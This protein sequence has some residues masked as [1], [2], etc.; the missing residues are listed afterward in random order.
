MTDE[1]QVAI[2][3][4]WIKDALAADVEIRKTEIN[5]T[6]DDDKHV[7]IEG[8]LGGEEDDDVAWAAL[9][10]IYVLGAL[11]FEDARPRGYSEADFV[12]KDAWKAEDM[13]RHLRFE[14]GELYFYADY[15]R[16]R[17]MKTTV[18]IRKDGTFTLE[19][20]NRGEAATR[21]AMRL[22]GKKI[23]GAVPSAAE[24]PG[25]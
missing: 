1:P 9:P 3:F 20:V 15:V 18:T 12:K 2:E 11:S 25:E 10:V 23:L 7:R 14:R 21:W 17:M 22:Q 5:P 24:L 16:G 8:R 4:E 6:T 19:S 13:L